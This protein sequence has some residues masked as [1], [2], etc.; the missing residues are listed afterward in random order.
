MTQIV[1]SSFTQVNMFFDVYIFR[2]CFF[3]NSTLISL[4]HS[5]YIKSPFQNNAQFVATP[6]NLKEHISKMGAIMLHHC[7]SQQQDVAFNSMKC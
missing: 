5:S 6:D 7:I 1:A 4:Q 2:F 3:M